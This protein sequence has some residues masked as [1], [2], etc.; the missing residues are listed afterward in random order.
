MIM[1]FEGIF[2]KYIICLVQYALF[3][4]MFLWNIPTAGQSPPVCP[5]P[6]MQNRQGSDLVK[7]LLSCL[8]LGKDRFFG[9]QG[10]ALWIAYISCSSRSQRRNS[11]M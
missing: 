3:L 1:Y 5:L 2:E 9:L 8:F 4:P 11:S 10:G 7:S 6:A